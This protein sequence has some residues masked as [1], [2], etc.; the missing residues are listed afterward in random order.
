M[1]HPTLR[2]TPQTSWLWRLARAPGRL[3]MLFML[4]LFEVLGLPRVRMLN[5]Q[6]LEPRRNQE[7]NR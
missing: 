1:M 5:C 3:L 2:S 4:S 7:K 6:P